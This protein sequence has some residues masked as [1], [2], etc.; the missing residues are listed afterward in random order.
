MASVRSSM[1]TTLP[2]RFDMRTALPSFITLTSW[3]MR[4]CM[5]SPGLSPNASHMAIMRPM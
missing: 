2:A 4:I 3:P 5:F 1:V